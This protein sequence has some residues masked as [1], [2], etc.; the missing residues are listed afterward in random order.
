MAQSRGRGG[1]SGD[2]RT[3]QYGACSAYLRTMYRSRRRSRQTGSAVC[4]RPK[5][6]GRPMSVRVWSTSMDM[7]SSS[8]SSSGAPTSEPHPPGSRS[9]FTAA[10]K[11]VGS[12]S[13]KRMTSASSSLS[14]R[15]SAAARA[16]TSGCGAAS[17]AAASAWGAPS[18]RAA[19][20]SSSPPPG[21]RCGAGG[22]GGGASASA[23]APTL[24]T[25]GGGWAATRRIAASCARRI[26]RKASAGRTRMLSVPR[27]PGLTMNA[28]SVNTGMP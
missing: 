28:F 21:A 4:G 24:A 3:C 5:G 12:C 20:A 9:E 25:S 17:T 14:T 13:V 10:P 26:T 18:S 27:K 15:R 2:A 1:G 7:K 6:P 8:S 19:S 22:S 11:P 23:A 16:S